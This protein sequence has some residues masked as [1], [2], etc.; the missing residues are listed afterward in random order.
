MRSRMESL[1]ASVPSVTVAAVDISWLTM[2]IGT[3]A[4]TVVIP[5]LRKK[6]QNNSFY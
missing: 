3:L 1:S 6:M 5:S 4:A 2:V